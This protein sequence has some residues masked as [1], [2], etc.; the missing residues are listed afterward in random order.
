MSEKS[1]FIYLQFI[2]QMTD[3][4]Q[5]QPLNPIDFFRLKS[6]DSKSRASVGNMTRAVDSFCKFTGGAEIK[7]DSFDES[8]LGEWIAHQLFYGYHTNT[9]AYNISKIAALYNKA[10]ESGMAKPNKAFSLV[11]AKVSDTASSRFDGLN[12]KEA[13]K[14]LQSIIRTDYSSQPQ[15]QLA[16]DV[17]L[18]AVY[19]GG[20]TFDQIASFKKDDYTGDNEHILD[21][22]NKY[23]KPKHKYLFPL[24]QA[25]STVK[26]LHRSIEA[27]L[28]V[29]L[30]DVNIRLSATP[31]DTAL[32][33]WCAVAMSCGISAS[34][35]AACVSPRNGTNALTAFVK[36]SEIDSKRISDIRNQVITTL[37]DNPVR[38]YVM[39]FR[40]HVDYDMLTA[41]L[42]EK[43]I[44]L[45]ETY[46]PME[47]IIHKVGNKKVF[48]NRPVI[49]WLLFFRERVTGLSKLYHEIGDLAWGYRQS[50]DIRSPYAS[51]SDKAVRDYQS[52]IGTL[53][54][55]TS[56]LP[57]EAI[58][59]NEGDYLVILGGALNGRPAVFISKKK[60]SK[61][62]ERNKI[63]FRVRLSGGKNANWIV[64]SDPRLVKK[65]TETQFLELNRQVQELLEE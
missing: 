12:H 55:D 24:N 48:E 18:F 41:R 50:R 57:D 23:S 42:N 29:L 7:F 63:V 5:I 59:F 37:T 33:L 30:S 36:P 10:V 62:I 38:W 47:E 54:P 44:N 8:L 13:F 46:Y 20:L 1:N 56:I 16:K 17:L 53:S 35:T 65:I 40:R 34:E 14:R 19:N 21:I 64:D 26:Q 58:E 3:T 2:Y 11:L 4:H 22:A 32:D 61:S 45:V 25:H 43:G 9:V 28:Y 60:S 15:K 39:H 52:A 51:I 49:S 6:A 27:M 31:T